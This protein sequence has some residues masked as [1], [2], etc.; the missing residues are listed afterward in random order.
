MRLSF[1]QATQLKEECCVPPDKN[2]GLDRRFRPTFLDNPLRRFLFPPQKFL[3]RH[4]ARGMVVADLGSGPGYLSLPA[5]E[6]V[7]E[8]GKVFSVDFDEKQ[9]ETLTRKSASRHLS[10]IEAHASSAANLDF[11]LAASIDVVIAKGLLCCMTDHK[12]ALRE[13]HRIMK[14][15][16]AAYFS[17]TMLGRKS[18]K[19]MVHKDEWELI[20][21]EFRVESRGEGLTRRWAW[22]RG[23][24]KS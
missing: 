16:G 4:L 22:V 19:R 18:D 8:K 2:V 20:L 13:I 6:I 24:A 15:D 17:V 1:G 9:I 11:I 21:N 7:G 14:P 10:S 3:N 23:S 5:A 12:G